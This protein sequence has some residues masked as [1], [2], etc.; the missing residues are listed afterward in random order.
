MSG[1]LRITLNR[2]VIG[3]SYK[4]K[5]IVRT[6]GLRRVNQTVEREDNPATRGM[7]DKVGH[8]VTVEEVEEE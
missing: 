3:Q 8:L 7:I 2:S 6:L 4:Q 1:R 5:R